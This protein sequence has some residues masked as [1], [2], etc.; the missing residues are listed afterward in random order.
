MAAACCWCV[1]LV[2]LIVGMIGVLMVIYGMFLSG[3]GPWGCK[4][5]QHG[6]QETE[7][8]NIQLQM[9]HLLSLDPACP[10]SRIAESCP[11]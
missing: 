3:Q 5:A 4:R 1:S 8:Q 7:M 11:V 10:G 6:G 2:R 9:E